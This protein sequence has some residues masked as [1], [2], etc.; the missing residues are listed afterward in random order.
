MFVHRQVHMHDSVRV[1]VCAR[2]PVRVPVR[3]CACAYV[4]VCVLGCGGYE[5]ILSVFLNRSLPYFLR[6]ESLIETRTYLMAGLAS[7][8]ASRISASSAQ[9]VCTGSNCLIHWISSSPWNLPWPQREDRAFKEMLF[10]CLGDRNS[11]LS[12]C[13]DV[14]NTNTCLWEMNTEVI[15]LC[16]LWMICLG[17]C[18]HSWI[19]DPVNVS[20]GATAPKAQGFQLKDCYLKGAVFFFSLTWQMT[21]TW[22]SNLA[23]FNKLHQYGNDSALPRRWTLRNTTW[24]VHF[25]T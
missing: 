2:V 7:P 11:Q 12:A 23:I 20:H 13:R 18:K 10:S 16:T 22:E 3:V 5:M 15:D 14:C 8:R 19:F 4:C 25:T 24:M 9:A 21:Q 17:K 6:Q 1:C